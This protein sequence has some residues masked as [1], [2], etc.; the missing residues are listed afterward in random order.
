MTPLQ[1]RAHKQSALGGAAAENPK[2]VCAPARVRGEFCCAAGALLTCE[3]CSVASPLVCCSKCG[4]ARYCGR[5]HQSEHWPEH[6]KT[7]TARSV[8]PEVKQEASRLNELINR[9]VS[10]ARDTRDTGECRRSF[11]CYQQALRL[12]FQ[13]QVVPTKGA[14]TLDGGV[15]FFVCRA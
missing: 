5:A 3:L 11:E 13:R 15:R 4:V 9:H 2:I 1:A 12:L 7:C 14:L 6:K 8:S 10:K